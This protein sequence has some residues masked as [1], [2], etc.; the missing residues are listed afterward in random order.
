LFTNFS[1]TVKITIENTT[2]D[3][4]RVMQ[5]DISSGALVRI[6]SISLRSSDTATL[7]V[8]GL[9]TDRLGPSGAGGWVEVPG[10][11]VTTATL[12]TDPTPPSGQNSWRFTPADTGHGTI[13]VSLTGGQP[14]ISLP[15]SF[16]SGVPV[17]L[18]IYP[19][20]G[21]PGAT[22]PHPQPPLIADTITAGTIY[23][24]LYAKLFDSYSG[25]LS[26][27]ESSYSLSQQIQW[28]V[29]PVDETKFSALS[30]YSTT[31][32]ATRAY[33]IVR[34]KATLNDLTDSVFLYVKS[35]TANHLVIEASAQV[36]DSIN[37]DPLSG[38]TISADQTFGYVYAILRDRF[39]NF[40]NYSKATKWLSFDTSV[41]K[42]DTGITSLGEGY[43][44]RNITQGSSKMVAIDTIKNFRDTVPVEIQNIYYTSLR[45][46]VLDNGP[47]YIDSIT[48]PKDAQLTLY[49]E[50]IRS[51]N[52]KWELVP[53][54]WILLGGL[55]TVTPPPTIMTSQWTI[56]PDSSGAGWIKVIK[57]EASP[58]SVRIF[59]TSGQ[60]GSIGIYKEA[61]NPFA[62]VPYLPK[63]QVNII[64]A[65]TTAPLFGDGAGVVLL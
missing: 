16:V 42:A 65:G 39:D 41:F 14:S 22:I 18:I 2:Y 60:P 46:Y 43:A 8:Q 47:K 34:V 27:Y 19:I 33:I 13:S 12:K 63:P 5:F 52:K 3:S 9:R 55:K 51:D 11:W 23:T 36:R 64:T 62:Q 29:M 4:L 37:A 1:D 32:S 40:V 49:V 56:T 53:A 48:I 7:Y 54:T 17:K 61:G 58:D 6:N 38:L 31:F 15:A 24:K 57:G 59:F 35:D 10:N 25:W 44:E 26:E 21:T 50:G 20:K 30:G 45:M 28:S